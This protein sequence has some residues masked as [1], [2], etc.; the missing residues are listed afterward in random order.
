MI[1]FTPAE[2]KIEF[3]KGVSEVVDEAERFRGLPIGES[4][5]VHGHI[6]DIPWPDA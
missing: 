6:F 5:P 1:E 4:L 2:G 3:D